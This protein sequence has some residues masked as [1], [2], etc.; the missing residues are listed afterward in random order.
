MSNLHTLTQ[1][2]AYSQQQDHKTRLK[3]S[4]HHWE[5]LFLLR[6]VLKK[7]LSICK[8]AKCIWYCYML[9]H[10]AIY[11]SLSVL[12][13][14]KF[15]CQQKMTNIVAANP[16]TN[17]EKTENKILFDQVMRRIA[18]KSTW[19]LKLCS[20]ARKDAISNKNVCAE[21]CT[22]MRAVCANKLFW[23]YM[24]V[25]PTATLCITWYIL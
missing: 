11:S 17:H 12:K 8:P 21:S 13:C 10:F 7:Q 3:A 22:P 18:K 25:L 20:V 5:H 14:P 6:K 23:F 2:W 19:R 16:K 1:K 24:P 9:P 15:D 4:Q